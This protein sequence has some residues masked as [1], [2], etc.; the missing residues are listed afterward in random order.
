[1]KRYRVTVL[2]FLL[3]MIMPVNAFCVDY[4]GVS[5][6]YYDAYIK[7]SSL[8]NY[9][10]EVETHEVPSHEVLPIVGKEYFPYTVNQF[11][12]KVDNTPPSATYDS[13]VLSKAD[14]VFAVGELSQSESLQSYIPVF[15]GKLES[16]SNHIDARVEKIQTQQANL[17]NGFPWTKDIDTTR[18]N[19]NITNSGKNV[20]MIGNDSNPGKN[21]LW[22]IPEKSTIK[23]N[24]AFDYNLDFGDSF[25]AAGF[26][27]NLKQKGEG[28]QGYAVVFMNRASTLFGQGLVGI[29]KIYYDGDNVNQFSDAATTSLLQLLTVSNSGRL[30]LE[31]T[32][33]SVVVKGGG[34]TEPVEVKLPATYG[35]GFGFFSEHYD[36]GCSN[37]GRFELTD[38][39]LK[40]TEAKSLGDALGDVSWREGAMRFIVFATDVVPDELKSTSSAGYK[41]MIQKLMN[42]NAYLIGLG[43]TTNRTQLRNLIAEIKNRDEEMGTYISNNPISTALDTSANW[44]INK[45]K[46]NSTS[47]HWILVGTRVDWETTYR[48][49]EKDLPLNFGKNIYDKLLAEEWG[50]NLTDYFKEG[51]I[52]AEKWR[53]RHMPDYYD[54]PIGTV[55]ADGIWIGEPIDVFTKTGEYRINYKR[56]DNPLYTNVSESHAF[57]EYRYWSTDYDPVVVPEEETE[58]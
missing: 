18:G 58:E 32:K 5:R 36:H 11:D 25:S 47:S 51:G 15:T 7:N 39:S 57:N 54:N 50:V 12:T 37:I 42:S 3:I 34:M 46:D 10:F 24:F 27:F 48:D 26:M 40:S 17:S 53:F 33:E 4:T 44:I 2:S 1:M 52:K 20:T 49:Y 22:V 8:G 29:Y 31:I 9:R 28:V 35:N 41:Y 21:A 56:K 43:T 14:I 45:V 13:M 38:I 23:Q 30:D 55:E 19:I 16:A 6:V